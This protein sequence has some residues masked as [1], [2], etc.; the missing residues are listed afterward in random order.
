MTRSDDIK[1]V[2]GLLLNAAGVLLNF[3]DSDESRTDMKPNL[4]FRIAKLCR[5]I[6]SLFIFDTLYNQSELLKKYCEIIWFARER[7]QLLSK[8][9]LQNEIGFVPNDVLKTQKT[10]RIFERSYVNLVYEA[11]DKVRRY[12]VQ[13]ASEF[14]YLAENEWTLS[15]VG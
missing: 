14:Q 13:L 10:K 7:D 4:V 2:Q 6:R 8:F 3:A 1:E 15:K 11:N 5:K 12:I 9:F